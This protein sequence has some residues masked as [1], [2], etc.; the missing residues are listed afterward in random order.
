M[1]LLIRGIT[2]KGAGRGIDLYLT[3]EDNVSFRDMLSTS[4][5]WIDA[6]S[7]IF[8]SLSLCSGILT[9]YSSYNPRDKPV[10]IDTFIIAITNSLV[11]FISGFTVFSMIGYLRATG[12]DTHV[13]TSSF[14]LAFISL[15]SAL[16]EISGAH[17]W[18]ITLFLTLFLLGI[19]SAFAM[20]EA[21]ATVLYDSFSHTNL[22]RML[23]TLG[24]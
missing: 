24:I 2:L 7:Q 17:F 4:E 16:S 22:S 6:I 12:N 9:S 15:P 8:F 21:S 1:A 5:I 3:G 18:N 10:I 23:Y 19:D 13:P 20:V 14:T 11:S